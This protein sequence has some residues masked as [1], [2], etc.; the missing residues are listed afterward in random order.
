MARKRHLELQISGGRSIPA[1]DV[2][3]SS[4]DVAR[5]SVRPIDRRCKNSFILKFSCSDFVLLV[6]LFKKSINVLYL[7]L[8]SND[9]NRNNLLADVE[10][11]AVAVCRI[12]LLFKNSLK[13]YSISSQGFVT[14]LKH[15]QYG[16]GFEL[17]SPSDDVTIRGT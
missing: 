7:K 5:K 14:A 15:L 13:V 4:A 8:L 10:V 17:L 11:S 6:L 2:G 12:N 16:L 3:E 9:L 1:A